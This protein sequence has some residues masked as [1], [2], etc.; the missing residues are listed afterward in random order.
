MAYGTVMIARLT[1]GVSVDDWLAGI[2]EW[3]KARNVPGFGGEYT[4][5]ADD[6]R[7]VSC[8]IFE[9]KEQYQTLADDP[10]QDAWWTAKARPL[11]ASDPE[12]IDGTW[13]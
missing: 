10:E 6:G 1:D 5:V 13:A 7:L 8:V 11:L 9:S 12:W 4:L 2:A 3:K